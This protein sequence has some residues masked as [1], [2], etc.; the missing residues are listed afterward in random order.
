MYMHTVRPSRVVA[1]FT[2]L[3]VLLLV[4]LSGCAGR[5]EPAA[6]NYAELL[7]DEQG[8]F[9]QVIPSEQLSLAHKMLSALGMDPSELDTVL[10][11]TRIAYCYFDL[12]GDGFSYSIIGR[13]RYPETIASLSLRSNAD[14]QREES[15]LGRSTKVR[16]WS[17]NVQGVRIS[18]LR[19]NTVALTNGSMEELLH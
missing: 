16:W 18:F 7:Y 9:L 11:R 1:A 6:L 4:L 17:N 12:R 8:I 19:D 2:S 3:V 15:N 14:W 5:P 10:T 13:G